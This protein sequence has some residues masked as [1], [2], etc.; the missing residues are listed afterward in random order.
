MCGGSGFGWVVVEFHYLLFDKKKSLIA[1]HTALKKST[2]CPTFFL[3]TP[4]EHS[5]VN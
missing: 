3:R 1:M 5:D 4:V 2:A